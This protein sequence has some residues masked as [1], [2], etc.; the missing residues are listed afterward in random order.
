[1]SYFEVSGKRAWSLWVSKNPQYSKWVLDIKQE[2]FPGD[3]SGKEPAAN[4]GDLNSV[5]KSG[6][7][8]EKEMAA[9]SSILA[10]RVHGQRSLVGYSP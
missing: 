8:P 3:A 5:P 1:M 9:H 10:G 7:S 4:A 6:R 2:G